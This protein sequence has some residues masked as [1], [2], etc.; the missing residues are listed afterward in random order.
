MSKLK[1]ISALVM[2][3]TLVLCVGYFSVMSPTS[4]WFYDSGVIDSGNSFVFG[5]VSVNTDYSLKETIN[6]DATT[7]LDDPDE[8][9]FDE[10][11]NVD[12]VS[13]TNSGTVPARVYANV[14]NKSA[15]KGLRWFY[16]TDD[17]LLESGVKKTIEAVLPNLTD[18]A[19]D[20]YNVGADGNSGHYILLQPGETTQVKLA[21]WIDYDDVASSINA[22][23]T[24][25]YD[26][27]ITLIASQNVDAAI[28]R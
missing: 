13:V 16:F 10:V 14:E 20:E 8:I 7:K 3:L 22:G 21:M 15:S 9:L 6:F 12:E 24:L 23:Q 28:E 1:R 4:A 19:L 18:K 5:D 25:D 2:A 27:E 26:V 17:M 11:I